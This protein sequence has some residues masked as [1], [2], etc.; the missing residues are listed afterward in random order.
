MVVTHEPNRDLAVWDLQNGARFF[1]EAVTHSH[2]ELGSGRFLIHPAQ[3]GMEAR[4]ITTGKP[5][6]LADWSDSR[7]FIQTAAAAHA[8][9]VALLRQKREPLTPNGD[10]IQTID[11]NS[12]ASRTIDAGGAVNAFALSPDGS[13][14]AALI[15]RGKIRIF[16]FD[17]NKPAGAFD[18]ALRD[19]LFPDDHILVSDDG[20]L[21]MLCSCYNSSSC[22]LNAWR[23]GKRVAA[24]EMPPGSGN[25]FGSGPRAKAAIAGSGEVAFIAGVLVLPKSDYR[26]DALPASVFDS[27]SIDR[28]GRHLLLFDGG[29]RSAGLR[30]FHGIGNL[31]SGA[32]AAGRAGVVRGSG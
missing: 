17:S 6:R 24:K 30:C 15:G 18:A 16:E 28:P 10:Q 13:K 31:Q 4:D 9:R 14:V 26:I 5:I 7:D 11:L 25:A 23:G 22:E 2:S 21:V 1:E 19:D 32:A 3:N 27:V 20:H 12:G 29:L 8:E